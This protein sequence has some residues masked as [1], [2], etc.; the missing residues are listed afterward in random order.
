M[1]GAQYAPIAQ[2]LE[3]NTYNVGVDGSSPSG[4]TNHFYTFE[5]CR[6][7]MQFNVGVDGFREH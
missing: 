6:N 3:H 2:W 1:V 4:R 5:P 7:F